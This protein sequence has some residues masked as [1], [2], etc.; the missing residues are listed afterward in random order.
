LLLGNSKPEVKLFTDLLTQAID[1][2]ENDQDDVIMGRPAH[3]EAALAA[4]V[5]TNLR[6]QISWTK[7]WS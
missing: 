7:D 1:C 3:V 2:A 5:Q 6:A 4:M